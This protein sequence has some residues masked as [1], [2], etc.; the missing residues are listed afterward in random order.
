MSEEKAW[1]TVSLYVEGILRSKKAV[2][3]KKL[4][5]PRC[6]QLSRAQEYSLV[7]N[8]LVPG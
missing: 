8:S 1:N 4:H 3:A 2:V 6:E 5:L 7:W